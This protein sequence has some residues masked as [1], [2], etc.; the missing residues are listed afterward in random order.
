V[1]SWRCA[2]RRCVGWEAGG[3]LA[4]GEEDKGGGASDASPVAPSTQQHNNNTRRQ[5]AEKLAHG[6]PRGVSVGVEVL[7]ECIPPGV[8]AGHGSTAPAG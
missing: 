2:R 1:T 8:R 5:R 4:L 7:L 3:L 6:S